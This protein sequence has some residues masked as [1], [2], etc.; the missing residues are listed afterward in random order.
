MG[1]E[2]GRIQTIIWSLNFAILHTFIERFKYQ[3]V[4]LELDLPQFQA[5]SIRKK[6]IIQFFWVFKNPGS[7]KHIWTK[8]K[9][10][11]FGPNPLGQLRPFYYNQNIYKLLG[12]PGLLVSWKNQ[13][14]RGGRGDFELR[15]EAETKTQKHL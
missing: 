7:Y 9:T 13:E 8:K 3:Q 6:I 14:G 12:N 15:Q 5:A 2:W 4:I 11:N 10:V 1:G